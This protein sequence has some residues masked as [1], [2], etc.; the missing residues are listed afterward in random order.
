MAKTPSPDKPVSPASFEAALREL[1]TIVASMEQSDLALEASLTS[2]QRGMELLKY[3]QDTLTAAENRI[4]VFEQ[5]SLR[6][7]PL[8][9]D[10][11]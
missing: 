9:A 11:D 1:E 3:C 5:G 8:P 2:Y 7:L 4:R 6:D 10:D